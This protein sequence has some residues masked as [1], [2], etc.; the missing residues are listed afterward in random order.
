MAGR[1]RQPIDIKS[2]EAYLNIHV[3]E[4]KTPLDV[5]QVSLR[6]NEISNAPLY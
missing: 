4:I 3:T 6:H 5:K 1:I 2:L